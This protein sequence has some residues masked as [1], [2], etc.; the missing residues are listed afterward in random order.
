MRGGGMVD[1]W[2]PERLIQGVG[3]GV[4]GVRESDE[5][6]VSAQV[7]HTGVLCWLRAPPLLQYN[8]AAPH[9][10][11]SSQPAARS[12]A[13]ATSGG[14]GHGAGPNTENKQT[15]NLAQGQKK[16]FYNDLDWTNW[17]HVLLQM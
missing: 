9:T 5:G 14:R 3:R 15:R 6:G 11:H 4:L 1:D 17:T 8:E 7:P 12:L 10:Q 16:K 13:A 2:E